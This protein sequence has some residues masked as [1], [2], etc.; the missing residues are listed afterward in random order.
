MNIKELK[1]IMKQ[2]NEPNEF[3]L[4]PINLTHSLYWIWSIDGV[5]LKPIYSKLYNLRIPE[6]RWDVF[7]NGQFISSNDYIYIHKSS[8]FILKFKKANFA[9]QLDEFD[10]IKIKG[11]LELV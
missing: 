6:N 1:D 2:I 9:Y 8:E 5:R 4:V 3:Q 10:E 7:V 11:D